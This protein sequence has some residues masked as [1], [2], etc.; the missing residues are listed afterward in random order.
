VRRAA[1]LLLAA[2]APILAAA[3]PAAATERTETFRTGPVTVAGYEVLQKQ[4]AGNLPKPTG[5]RFITRM[6]VDVVDADGTP[7]PIQRLMLHHIVFLNAGPAFGAKRDR[8]CGSF[9][10]LDSR[11]EVPALAERF[12]AAGEERLEMVL[13][14]GYGYRSAAADQWL[15]T[16]MLMNHRAKAD[17]AYIQYTVTTDDSPSLTPVD[18]YWL[19]VRDCWSDPVYDVPGGGEPGATDVQTTTWRPP[20]AGRI[21][22]GGGHVH[23]GGQELRLSQPGC[24]DRTLA[25]SRPTWG[26]PSHPFYNVK[27]VLHEPGPIAMSGFTTQQGFRVAAGEPVRFASVYDAERPHTR[28]MGIEI[29]YFAPD[30]SATQPC[31]P[32]PTDVST[33]AAGLPGRRAAPKVTVPL[34][35]LDR[36]GRA[37]RIDGPPGRMR[38]VRGRGPVTVGV[39]D[40]RFSAPNL[41]VRPGARIRWRFGG[42]S[43]HDVTLAS[44]PR[45]FSSHHRDRGT[46]SQ[47]LRKRGTYRLFCS[48]HP[49]AMTQRIVVR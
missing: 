32:L 49:V 20:T 46:F 40:M 31:A 37:V 26:L 39:R 12:Y 1:V 29:V 43:L 14:P 28:V 48:L 35:G 34:T 47:R 25:S 18:P 22:A 6:K 8:T 19:D 4:L 27:P 16:Y 23:G 15:M 38:R 30:A 13:P 42:P 2:L 5:D 3:G 21:V 9:R 17:T 33:Y 10:M 24:G 41:R 45:G 11:S 36:R 7:V 44:G